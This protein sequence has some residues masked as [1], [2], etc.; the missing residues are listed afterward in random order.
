MKKATLTRL[1]STALAA[2]T[3]FCFT[4]CGH[5][6]ATSARITDSGELV[7]TYSGGREE[8]LGKL[9]AVGGTTVVIDGVE[10][11]VSA[12]TSIGL[13]SAVSVKAGFT[14]TNKAP[15]YGILPGYGK[16]EYSSAGSGVIYRLDKNSGDA[17]I[18]TNYHVIYD[19][20]SDS[21]VSRKISVMLYGKE[22]SE[23][24][25][26]A[27]YVGGSAYYDIAVLHVSGA[28]ALRGSVYRAATPS[29]ENVAAGDRAIAIGNPESGGIA[30]SQGIISVSSEYI[31]MTA[32][33]GASRVAH[34]VIRV[35]TAVNSGNSGGG[36]YSD[37]GE[38]L[39]IVNAKIV[40][41]SVENIGYA[42]PA[43]VAT[44]VAD[45]IIDNCYGR[46][47]TTV[48]R[49]ELGISLTATSSEAQVCADG[50][51]RIVETVSVYGIDEG[52][53]AENILKSGDRLV[54]AT[55]GERTVEIDRTYRLIDLMLHARAGDT[56]SLSVVRDG[57]PLTLQIQITDGMISPR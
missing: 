16:S 4:A 41:E 13:A 15:S 29:T 12:A 10:G 27:E 19:S 54:S 43:K 42:I 40:D 30:A 18:I 14:R 23:Y 38:L 9:S 35:D 33:D 21:G 2:L 47:C 26:E 53:A 25:I 36:L 48:M 3:V 20:A 52:S 24:A 46:D 37:K 57:A 34:R 8:N 44:A 1:L 50:S 55:L 5:G 11:D 32:A 17:F 31:T 49:A 28:E 6:T 7:V 51:L 39:G 45:N 56:L 22:Q